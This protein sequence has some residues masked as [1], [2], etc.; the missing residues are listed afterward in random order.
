MLV[1]AQVGPKKFRKLTC[2]KLSLKGDSLDTLLVTSIR[3][4]V[5]VGLALA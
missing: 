2:K 1:C 5:S 4:K 3:E